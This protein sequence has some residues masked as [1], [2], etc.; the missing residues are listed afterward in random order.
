M[1]QFFAS[2]RHRVKSTAKEAIIILISLK[3][4]NFEDKLTELFRNSDEKLAELPSERAW[5]KLESRL[6]ARI[7]YRK[8]KRQEQRKVFSRQVSLAAGVVGLLV[9]GVVFI[10]MNQQ[11][12]VENI[13]GIL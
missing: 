11:S 12:K 5:Q 3:M 8:E 7:E 4:N 2:N 9:T 13:K 10:L 6:N 1:N